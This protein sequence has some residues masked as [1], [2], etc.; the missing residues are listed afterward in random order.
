MGFDLWRFMA[1]PTSAADRSRTAR[2]QRKPVG[3]QR[4]PVPWWIS[5]VFFVGSAR[6]LLGT[7]VLFA[8]ATGIAEPMP[9]WFDWLLVA[10][11]VAL[12]VCLVFM[13]NGFAFAR[14]AWLVLVLAQ[15]VFDQ[16]AITRYYLMFDAVLLAITL[17]PASSRYMG[18][19]A[20]ARH[21][22]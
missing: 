20:D 8:L 10:H 19:C 9:A 1:S 11:G 5:V 16:T 7:F 4:P 22:N 15:L 14:L 3:V 21:G 2:R 13:L 12:I 17:L 6:V 18:L